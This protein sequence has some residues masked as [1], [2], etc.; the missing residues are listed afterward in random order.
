MVTQEP[1][2]NSPQ[3]SPSALTGLMLSGESFPEE[4]TF[5]ET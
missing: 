3:A 2:S 4:F 1:I 5:G